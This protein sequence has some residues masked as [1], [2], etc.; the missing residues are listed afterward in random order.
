MT[1]PRLLAAI[2]IPIALAVVLVL[3]IIN[4]RIQDGS[5]PPTGASVAPATTAPA[6]KSTVPTR[7]ATRGEDW[8]SIIKEIIRYRNSLY[9]N[10]RPELLVN[11][12]DKKCPCYKREYD[13]LNQLKQRGLRYE[14]GAVEVVRV[15]FYGRAPQDPKRVQLEVFSKTGSQSILDKSGKIVSHL[16]ATKETRYVYQL[17]L[18]NDNQWRV[19]FFA[20]PRI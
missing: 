11:I 3:V 10:P 9:E 2:A 19:I 4:S 16:P 17:Q 12:Y 8:S 7:P 18:G 14:A 1:R 5:P 15:K 13:E 20:A 6:V